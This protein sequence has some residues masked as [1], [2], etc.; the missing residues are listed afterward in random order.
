M[1]EIADLRAHVGLPAP[2]QKLNE[3]VTALRTGRHADFFDDP[4]N[5]VRVRHLICALAFCCSLD[6][7]LE[8]AWT[9]L[10]FLPSLGGAQTWKSGHCSDLRILYN[11]A[12]P[13]STSLDSLLSLSEQ[14][15]KQVI[16]SGL[17]GCCQ[18]HAHDI[19]MCR[20]GEGAWALR[21]DLH[22]CRSPGQHA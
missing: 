20:Q 7:L 19:G 3:A 6:R 2:L 8:E 13:G 11:R 10:L 9:A 16:A 22:C 14:T 15:L 5:N 1:T 12:R 4:V 17:P 21:Q 18:L